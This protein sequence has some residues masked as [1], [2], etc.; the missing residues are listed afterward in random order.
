MENDIVIGRMLRI[1]NI[2]G[3]IEHQAKLESE[4]EQAV[5]KA[6]I[7]EIAFL[8]AQINPHFLNNTLTLIS[9]MVTREPQKAKNMIV[10]LSEYLMNCYQFNAE[11]PLTQLRDELQFVKTYVAI[12]KARFM[13]RLEVRFLDETVPDVKIPRLVIQPLVENAIRHGVLKRVSGGIITVA[14][15]PSEHEVCI[16]IEDDGVGIPPEKVAQLLTGKAE[17]QGVGIVNIQK[18]LLKYY[19]RGLQLESDLEK[20]TCISFFLPID[21]KEERENRDDTG[22]SD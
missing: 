13:E 11:D 16:R 4:I 8:Q 21:T 15:I 2:T 22:D 18:R 17:G 3:F 20:G 19:G 6:E 1:E 14:V 12:E 10:D 9:A 7:N 5:E